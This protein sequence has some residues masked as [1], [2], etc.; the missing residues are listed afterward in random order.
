MSQQKDK[1]FVSGTNGYKAKFGYVVSFNVEEFKKYLDQHNDKGWAKIH[2]K[3]SKDKLD[4]FQRTVVYGEK[5]E[6][7]QVSAQGNNNDIPQQPQYLQPNVQEN[8]DLAF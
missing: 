4:K 3:E 7:M 8:D 5:F 1:T 6:P 2:F